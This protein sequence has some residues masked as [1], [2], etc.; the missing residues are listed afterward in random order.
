MGWLL[1]SLTSL[2]PFSA[3][4]LS[5]HHKGYHAFRR[6][7]FAR[8]LDGLAIVFHI[9]TI[10]LIFQS[11]SIPTMANSVPSRAARP[12]HDPFEVSERAADYVTV[13]SSARSGNEPSVPAPIR[14]APL[15]FAGI[16][17]RLENEEASKSGHPER[18]SESPPLCGT[19]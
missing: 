15:A 18:Q 1:R 4:P 16:R 5:K 19:H 17:H 3:S 12:S 6:S 8:P 9:L 7:L 10:H 13:T 14:K 11:Y 2:Q